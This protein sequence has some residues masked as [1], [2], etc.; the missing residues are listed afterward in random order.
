[1]LKRQF[2]SLANTHCSRKLGPLF[3]CLPL[4]PIL[5]SLSSALT[6][7]YLDDISFEGATVVVAE[8]VKYIKHECGLMGLA[9]NARSSHDRANGWNIWPCSNLFHQP[10]RRH[11][12]WEH[13]Y[14]QWKL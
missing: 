7:G 3:F 9:K 8:N 5:Q 6:L 12:F 13:H 4:Q 11:A 1:M 10:R 14:C 2:Y